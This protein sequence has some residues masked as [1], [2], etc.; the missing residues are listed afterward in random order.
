MNPRKSLLQ[1]F[2]RIGGA[3]SSPHRLELLDLLAQGEK[4]VQLLATQAGLSL[5]NASAHLRVLRG[6]RLVETRKEG[7][8]VHYRLADAEVFELL[9]ATE[10]LAEKRLAE[11]QSILRRFYADPEG[12]EATAA[13]DL[14]R[15]IELGDVT[16]IDVRP[17]DEYRAGHLPGAI[18]IPLPDLEQRLGALP[19]DQEIIAYCRG[20]Y[21][22]LAVDAV[23]LLRDKGFTA[24]RAEVGVPD[25]RAM[26]TP[27]Q[28]E[29]RSA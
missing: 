26:P 17:E 1:E 16:L 3:L 12:F 29:R 4:P 23:R 11:V 28:P 13:A 7:T 21:C 25:M 14:W 18:S 24:R 6:A 2:A 27:S 19:G 5:K 15:R 10:R 8:Q 22:M 20:P 9:R